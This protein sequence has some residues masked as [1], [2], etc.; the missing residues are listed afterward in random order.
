MFVEE[1]MQKAVDAC[2]RNEMTFKLAASSF[3]VPENTLR[4]R[5]NGITKS[6]KPGRKFALTKSEEKR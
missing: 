5:V 4:K 2:R 1:D 3:K 6:S